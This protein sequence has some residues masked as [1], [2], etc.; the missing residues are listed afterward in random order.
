MITAGLHHLTRYRYSKPIRLGP[1]VIRLRPAPHSRTQVPNYSLKISPENHFLNWQQDPH[2]N[3]LARLVFPD[4]VDHFSIEVDLLADMVVINPFD[5]FVEDYAEERPF[6]YD[7]A[8]KED[9]A[10]YFDVE[11]QGALFEKLYERFADVKQRTVDFLVDVNMAVYQAVNYVI[12]MEAGVQEPEETLEVGS[13]SCRD[14]AW[15]LVNLLRR[16]GFAAR[17]V[18]GYSIQMT[19]DVIPVDGPKGVSQDVCDLHAWAEAYVPGAGWI[20][21]DATSGMLAGEGHI[22]LC[23]TPH[24]RSAAPI[25]GLAE[26]AEVDFH[27]EMGVHRIHEAVRITK[28]FTDER[29]DAVLA[30]GDKVDEDIAAQDMRLT[31]GGEPTFIA[32]GDFEAPEWNS[33]A[34]GPT[35]A[36]Y[37]DRLIRRLRDEFAPGSLLHHGQGKWYPGESLPRWGYS[38]YWRKDGVP[39]WRD[40]TLIAGETLPR[41]TPP[42]EV[43]PQS[44]EQV[45]RGIAATLGVDEEFVQPVYE[46]AVEWIV[47]EAQLPDNVAPDDPELENPEE[48]ARFMRTFQRGLNK[49]VGYVLPVQRWWQ[50]AHQPIRRWRSEKWRLRRGALY[51]VPGDAAL[52]YRLP[53]SSLPHV[54]ASDY[55]FINPQDTA[56]PLAPLPDFYGLAAEREAAARTQGAFQRVSDA[57]GQASGNTYVEQV[58]IEGVVR[59]AI[60]VEARRDHLC[61]FIPPVETLEDYLDLIATV[62]HVAQESG[63]PVRIEGYP[64]PADPRLMVL[65]VTPDPGVIEVNIQPSASWRESVHITETLYD[66]AR[67]V[68]LTAD[69]FMVDGRAVG[70]GGGNHIV[71]GGP[72]LLDSPFIRRPDLLKS[73]VTYWQR[74]P[75]LSYLFSGLCIGPTSQAPRIDEARHDGLYELEIALAQVPGPDQ[76]QPLAWVVDRLF[77]NLLVDVTGNTHRTEICIDKLFSPDGPTG[78]LGLVEFRGFEMPP[79][80]KMSL[81]QQLLIRALAAWFWREPQ[82]GP[83]VRWGTQLHDRFMLGHFVWADF[84]DVLSDL[85]RAGY[86]FDPVWFEAQRQFRFPIHGT[87]EGGGVQLEIAH[88]LEPWNVLGETG[89]IGGTVRFVDSS[90]ERL[91]VR[92]TGLVAGRHIITCNGR[93]IPMNPTGTPGEGVGGVRYKAW[94]PSNCLHPMLPPHAPLTFDIYDTWNHRSLGGAVYEVAHPG[95]RNYDT[96]PVNAFEAEGRR[97]ARFFDI[98]HT[99]GFQ[100]A[101]AQEWHGEF[102]MT[103]DLR[104][105]GWLG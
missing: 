71:L 100:P 13:G 83:L 57:P 8:L 55:P 43:A 34:V 97:K 98:G 29:W 61:V 66:V 27:F 88:A 53:L 32:D 21:M 50:A 72:S 67:E 96:V 102:P 23:A 47:R 41:E 6:A 38:I 87:T 75:S 63:L 69:R 81:A 18:S 28:P 25:S 14:S 16:L 30:L 62:E 46:D 79:D 90:T 42:P 37:A 60:T 3:W 5:F 51:A 44:A 68:G 24:Y 9:L 33:D 56:A 39:V 36:A 7:P 73:F 95:G 15:L 93:R 35:K 10:A 74:H 22:P 103:L 89:A 49:P 77:R 52:G 12:R 31:I 78:R 82:G 70:T 2:G 91:Q 86:D 64:P 94:W 19:P 80:A 20:A 76:P 1:Q 4:P 58:A 26:P 105:P 40:A 104:R 48:R 17:F 59:T 65:K 54:A 92:A 84:L 45:M 85:R 99:P 101:P 11:P